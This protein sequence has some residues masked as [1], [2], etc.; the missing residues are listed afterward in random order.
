MFRKVKLFFCC[1]TATCGTAGSR[2][3]ISN[4][5]CTFLTFHAIFRI[6]TVRKDWTSCKKI[7]RSHLDRVPITSHRLVH[8]CRWPTKTNIY[9]HTSQETLSSLSLFYIGRL[10]T[11]N[12]VHLKTAPTEVAKGT[13]R[14]REG[15]WEPGNRNGTDPGAG[16]QPACKQ[17]QDKA[18]REQSLLSLTLHHVG[19]V[20]VTSATAV[21]TFKPSGFKKPVFQR[22]PVCLEVLP[23]FQQMA[24]V[25]GMG[26]S[27]TYPL[28]RPACPKA[29]R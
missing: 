12:G 19:N 6:S 24:N 15:N 10:P 27:W 13:D 18:G 25:M 17:L 8:T 9:H 20:M 16:K 11:I 5:P 23:C 7:A 22:K 1:P 26:Q 2:R 28:R 14:D 4:S 3:Q 21:T 29:T